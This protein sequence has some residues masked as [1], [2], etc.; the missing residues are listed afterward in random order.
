MKNAIIAMLVVVLVGCAAGPREVAVRPKG[1]FASIDTL[2][3]GSTIKAVLANDGATIDSVVSSPGKYAP[4]VLYALSSVLFDAGR[5]QE[6]VFWF[7]AGQ[8]RARSDANKSLDPSAKQAMA[9]LNDQYGPKINKFAFSDIE[10]LKKTINDVSEWDKRTE[11]S[12]DARW[13]ALH[14]MD[15]LTE[16]KIRF[17]PSSQWEVIDTKTRDDYLNGF[18]QALQTMKQ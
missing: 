13:I 1:E 8:L 16:S 3:V 12:Y 15:S 4:P 9:V 11:R 18:K 14:G 2:S 17:A 10:N 5:K 6:G 7:Y